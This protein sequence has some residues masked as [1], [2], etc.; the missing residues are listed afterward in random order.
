MFLAKP[1]FSRVA[2]AAGL[3]VL[4]IAGM[5]VA[6]ATQDA[7]V[8]SEAQAVGAGQ[9]VSTCDKAVNVWFTYDVAAGTYT[10]L[11]VSEISQECTGRMVTIG[12]HSEAGI[13]MPLTVSTAPV[14]SDMAV[15]DI[16][17]LDLAEKIGSVDVVIG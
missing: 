3:G 17:E 13:E 11:I 15:F 2:L 16:S 10:E 4:G 6:S 12:I 8:T 1:G 14:G 7:A 9:F 5:S